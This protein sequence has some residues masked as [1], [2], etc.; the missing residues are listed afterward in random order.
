MLCIIHTWNACYEPKCSLNQ[1]QNGCSILTFFK[2]FLMFIQ[3]KGSLVYCGCSW[4]WSS[5]LCS[6]LFWLTTRW[7]FFKDL[8]LSNVLLF[9]KNFDRLQVCHFKSKV[10]TEVREKISK[11]QS[12]LPSCL[13]SCSPPSVCLQ[14]LCVAEH[15]VMT[16]WQLK[17]TLYCPKK[18]ARDC[19]KPCYIT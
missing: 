3:F 6:Q 13:S 12:T 4:F 5:F 11:P 1:S 19:F 18:W 16:L 8:N 15:T 10:M 7:G 9:S 17:N 2:I 14:R